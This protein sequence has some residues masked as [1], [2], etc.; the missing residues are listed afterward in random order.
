MEGER[1]YFP[2]LDGLRFVAFL[3]VFLHHFLPSAHLAAPYGDAASWV[4]RWLSEFG[5]SG[6]DLFFVL[7]G[8]LITAL[9]LRERELKGRIH[10]GHFYR[11][12]ILRIWPLYY[13]ACLCFFLIFPALNLEQVGPTWGS[14]FQEW[15]TVW[16]PSFLAFA[17]NLA[18]SIGGWTGWSVIDPL[19]SISMEEQFYLVWPALVVLTPSKRLGWALLALIVVPT[20]LRYAFLSLGPHATHPTIFTHP[21]CRFD[22]FAWGALLAVGL[23]H[24]T[25]AGLH[26]RF[27]WTLWLGGALIFLPKALGVRVETLSLAQVWLYPVIAV[28]YLS[29]LAA[30]LRPTS[31][32]ARVFALPPLVWLGRLSYGLYVWHGVGLATTLFYVDAMPRTWPAWFQVLGVALGITLALA[33]F[34]YF[35]IERP[36]LRLKERF[37][38][39]PSRPA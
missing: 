28:G 26:R 16:I 35:A 38:L 20:W 22:S 8:Y 10:I 39:V 23:N 9:L 32:V 18:V 36:F 30:L 37:A 24:P 29:L 19:W 11:R 31:W 34:S 25:L 6:V 14:R 27:G 21:F 15:V 12:R 4:S 2:Q 17:G 5:W 3:L 33:T 13:F 7:S 1:F